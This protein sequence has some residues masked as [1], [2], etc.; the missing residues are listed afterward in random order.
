PFGIEW[1]VPVFEIEHI[2]TSA[3]SYSRNQL[4]IITNIGGGAVLRGFSFP[5]N[6]VSKNKFINIY[7]QL[8]EDSYRDITS[9]V[10]DIKRIEKY[11]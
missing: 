8:I 11:S 6:E 3:L 7:G 1:P 9:V 4:H 2:D 10:F 5:R